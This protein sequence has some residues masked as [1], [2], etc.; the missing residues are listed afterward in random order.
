MREEKK[1]VVPNQI[2]QSEMLVCYNVH[3]FC[4]FGWFGTAADSEQVL[5]AKRKSSYVM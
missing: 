2:H 4:K 1:L 5:K 3:T